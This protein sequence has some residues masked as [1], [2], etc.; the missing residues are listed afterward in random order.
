MQDP[1]QKK[2][3]RVFLPKKFK[4]AQQTAVP[5]VKIKDGE[6][7]RRFAIVLIILFSSVI[8]VISIFGDYGFIATY[9]LQQKES[10]LHKQITQLEEQQETLLLQIQA[11]RDNP[12][13][14]KMEIRKRLGLYLTTDTIYR[15]PQKEDIPQK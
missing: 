6:W 5:K 10:Q 2:H 8:V 15:I 1:L 3:N 13:Y 11:L 14:L 12:E 7:Q 4:D 9:H